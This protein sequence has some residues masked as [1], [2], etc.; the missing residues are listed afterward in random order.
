[1]I[2]FLIFLGNQHFFSK[3]RRGSKAEKREGEA[4]LLLLSLDTPRRQLFPDTDGT[5]AGPSTPRGAP[6]AMS[7]GLATSS[8]M[9]RIP[10]LSQLHSLEDLVGN[11]LTDAIDALSVVPTSAE[12]AQQLHSSP[13]MHLKD[14]PP[15][16]PQSLALRFPN[17]SEVPA[18]HRQEEPPPPPQPLVTSSLDDR[19]SVSSTSAAAAVSSSSSSSTAPLS[20]SPSSSPPSHPFF[21]SIPS[22]GMVAA[23]DPTTN[24]EPLPQ[25]PLQYPQH[26]LRPPAAGMPLCTDD[27]F[28]GG[29]RGGGGRNRRRRSG[30]SVSTTTSH[31]SHSSN[32]GSDG[33]SDE[34]RGSSASADGQ[35]GNSPG[36][37]RR[38]GSSVDDKSNGDGSGGGGRLFSST[39]TQLLQFA[40]GQT[41][42][43]LILLNVDRRVST[44][45]VAQ[46]CLRYGALK[47]LETE[48]QRSFGVVFVAYQDLRCAEEAF[49]GVGHALTLL[50][51][52]SSSGGDDPSTESSSSSSEV[53]ARERWR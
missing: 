30:S 18:G 28:L 5:G 33:C 42:R 13:L 47:Y 3:S 2:I 35:G 24:Q 27:E 14:C 48:F 34:R 23:R 16:M 6:R 41:S 7:S 17:G 22:L 40:Q 45:L 12:D 11:S 10:S 44:D 49:R 9:P 8:S 20:S 43:A 46:Q 32:D 53:R 52:P 15:P 39:W 25:P 37:D 31:D 4:L 1:M 38:S 29:G 26:D 50:S 51:S 36:S 21:A 19:T